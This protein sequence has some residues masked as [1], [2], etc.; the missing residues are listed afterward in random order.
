MHGL[1]LYDYGARH[2]DAAIGRWGTMDPL[3]EKYYSVSPYVYCAN[4]PI[5]A[6]DPNGR[7]VIFINGLWGLKGMPTS[8]GTVNHWG[9]SWVQNVQNRIGDHRAMFF[10]GSSLYGLWTLCW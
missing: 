6:I 8:G 3:A 10:D 7:V 9:R 1:D 2:L 5:N 4:N